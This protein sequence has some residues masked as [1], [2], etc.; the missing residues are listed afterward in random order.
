MLHKFVKKN[1]IFSD[2]DHGMVI[3]LKYIV[4]QMLKSQENEISKKVCKTL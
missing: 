4:M 3:V 2:G 1:P